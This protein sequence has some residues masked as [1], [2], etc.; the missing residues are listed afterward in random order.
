VTFTVPAPESADAY[1]IS[2]GGVRSLKNGRTTGGLRVTLEEFGLVSAVLLTYDPLALNSLT[3]KL[4][5]SQRRA[6]ELQRQIATLRLADIEA[7]DRQLPPLPPSADAL[8]WIKLAKGHLKQSDTNFAAGQH[9]VAEAFQHAARALRPLRMV[10]R[11]HWDQAQRAIGSP[12]A[13]PAGASYSTL[14]QFWSFLNA[15]RNG[16]VGLNVLPAG[17]CESLN[18]LMQSGWR[19]FEHPQPGLQT[20]VQLVPTEPHSGHTSLQLRVWPADPKTFAGLVE[21][22]P[23]WITTAAVPVESGQLVRI[24][25]WVD[26]PAAISGSVDGLMIFDS[27]AG[28]ELAQRVGQTRGWQEFSLYRIAPQTGAMTVTFALTG[29]GAARIDDV[30]IEPISLAAPQQARLP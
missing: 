20:E 12:V 4:Q 13:V 1:E 18:R 7:V 14:P 23:V 24:R 9:H 15:V 2:P 30:A 6:V 8:A 25:G 10:E 21:T 28:P 16:Q 17:D 29:I 26:V 27:L 3:K 5:G 11:A 22:P 19:H